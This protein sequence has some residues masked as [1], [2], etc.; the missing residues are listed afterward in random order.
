MS[1]NELSK[2]RFA[3]W[4]LCQCLLAGYDADSPDVHKSIL[5]LTAIALTDGLDTA[6]TTRIANALGVTPLEVT[7]A[8]LEEMRQSALADLLAHPCLA[9]VDAR[10]DDLARRI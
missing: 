5:A 6:T 3:S 2:S 4:L 8:Y 7:E 1:H 10:L 9:E